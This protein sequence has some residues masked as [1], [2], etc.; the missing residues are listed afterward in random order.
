[1]VNSNNWDFYVRH[2]SEK[3]LSPYLRQC[4][5]DVD[6]AMRLYDWNT[7]VSSVLWESIGF[8]EISLRNALDNQLQERQSRLH[9][10]THWIFDDAGELGR[11]ATNPA[12]SRQPFKS[13]FEATSRIRAKQKDVTPD[14]ILAELPLGFWHQLVAKQ[15]RFLWPDLASGFPNMPSRSPDLVASKV[16]TVRNLRNRIGHHHKIFQLD[17]RH[18][19]REITSLAG[20]IDFRLSDWIGNESRLAQMMDDRP[21]T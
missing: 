8:L 12:N 4:D 9:R 13:I 5:G 7:Q 20:F 21:I 2:F 19:F 3:R 16:E 18:I 14:R 17:I 10:D 15:Q 1:M 11:N 6:N